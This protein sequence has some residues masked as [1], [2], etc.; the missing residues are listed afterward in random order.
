MPSNVWGTP[1]STLD[2]GDRG[3]SEGARGNEVEAWSW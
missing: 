3:W 1:N 2:P